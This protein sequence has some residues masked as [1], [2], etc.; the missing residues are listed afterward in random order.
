M[1]LSLTITTP[2][3]TVYSQEVDQVSVTT[4]LGEITVLPNHVPM[5]STLKV[6]HVVVKNNNKEELF[7]IDGGLLEVRKDHSV[8]IL[9][10]RSEHES[11]L[12]MRRAEKAAKRAQEF[13]AQPQ[14]EIPNYAKLQESLAKEQNR[15]RVAKRGGRR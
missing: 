7:A 5:I 6:G 9:S 1:K 12:D 2:L 10:D 14:V 4:T 11:E 15:I 8:V 3:Q 13:L